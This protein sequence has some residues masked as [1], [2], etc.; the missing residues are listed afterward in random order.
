M[1]VAAAEVR[2]LK[3]VFCWSEVPGYMPSCWRALAARPGVSL[4]ILHPQQLYGHLANPFEIGSLMDGL[5]HEMFHGDR[6]DLDRWLRDAVTAQQPDVVVHC[7]WIFWPYTRLMTAR[8]LARVP[9]VVG[10]DTPWR[11]TVAQRLARFR[12]RAIARR[13]AVVVA[14]GERSAEYARR[15]GF[16]PRTIVG[17]YYGF[18]DRE[19]REVPGRRGPVWPRQFLFVGRYVPQKDLA[20]LVKGYARYRQQVRDPWPLTCCGD[21]PDRGV[22]EHHEG[23]RNLGFQQPAQLPDILA[24]HGAFVM[25]SKFEPWGV[26]IAEAAASGLPVVCTSACGAS[27]DLVRDYYSGL[28]V[29][30][31]DPDSLA[32]A[33]SWIHEHVDALAVMGQRGRE[34]SHAFTA[35]AWA[36]RWHQYLLHAAAGTA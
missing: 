16:D 19:L 3:V 9:M 5:S 7:G 2:A 14:A 18:D 26:V 4:H 17:G 13:T 27:V 31:E 30:P 23:I 28:I 15:I 29:P 24:A 12:L 35:D 34:L 10:M 11:G 8:E 33:L 21:G 32:R 36:T 25:P 22:L 1:A 20:T 6:P